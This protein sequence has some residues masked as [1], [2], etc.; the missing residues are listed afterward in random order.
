MNDKTTQHLLQ[1]Q[2]NLNAA[3]TEW[4]RFNFIKNMQSFPFPVGYGLYYDKDGLEKI[5]ITTF[6]SKN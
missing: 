4:T 6:F 2:T 3:G 1:L 5:I